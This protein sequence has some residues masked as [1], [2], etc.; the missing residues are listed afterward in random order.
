MSLYGSKIYQQKD[1]AGP[2]RVTASTTLT[3]KDLLVLVDS[4]GGAVALTLPRLHEWI[5]CFMSIWK[6]GSGTND[7]TLLVPGNEAHDYA[8][9][10]AAGINLNAA[11]DHVILYN[12]GYGITLVAN[13][14]A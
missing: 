7:I 5:G 8:A 13:E 10:E 2:L 11:D 3:G 4:S 9:L 12:D 1:V 6:I 14:I